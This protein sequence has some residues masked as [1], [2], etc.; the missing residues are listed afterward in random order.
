MT[1]VA[2]R[3]ARASCR[4]RLVGCRLASAS[5]VR[6]VLHVRGTRRESRRVTVLHLLD[7]ALEEFLRAEVP[8]PKHEY[9]VSFAAPDK[10]WAAARSS[11]TTVNVYLRDV[12]RNTQLRETGLERVDQDGDLV[13]RQ[14]LPLVDCRYLITVWA[15]DIGDEH[16]TLGSVLATLLTN[17]FVPERHLP[18]AYASVRP[19]P[20]LQLRSGE[21]GDDSDFWSALGGQLKPGLDVVVSAAVEAGVVQPVGPPV[22]RYLLRTR[23]VDGGHGGERRV[24]TDAGG[25][26]PED[27]LPSD[28]WRAGPTGDGGGTSPERPPRQRRKRSP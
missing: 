7:E 3:T 17:A 12:R 26:P 27:L 22:D 21:G 10:S 8:L 24:P 1:E 13:F 16:S 23:D 14:P 2:R 5:P 25:P 9:D 19:L 28:L 6:Y 4:G 18:P 15:E 20:R 11:T